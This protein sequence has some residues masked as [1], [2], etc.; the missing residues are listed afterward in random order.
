MPEEAGDR[1]ENL[2]RQAGAVLMDH[3]G[4]QLT[5]ETK[6]DQS[7]VT[8]ADLASEKLL[9]SSLRRWYPDD[10]VLAEE[11][12]LSSA[13]RR[14]GSAIWLIDP[15]DGTTNFANDYPFFCIS[16]ARGR[17]TAEGTIEPEWGAIYDPVRDELFTASA[18]KGAWCN[19]RRLQVR[20]PRPLSRCFLA[21]GYY[22]Q[23]GDVLREEVDRF[24]AVASVCQAIRRDGAAALDLAWVAR[25]TYDAFWEKG[26]QLWD[27][28][29][30]V[31]LIREAGGDVCNYPTEDYN[32][33]GEGVIAGSR[34]AV[35][36]VRDIINPS[37]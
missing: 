16:V 27:L 8:A 19:G 11:S 35:R 33:E 37:P 20:P 36:E 30:G 2:V 21:M 32:L 5:T 12:G 25:G 4:T 18:G 7:L 34:C 29:A 23:R 10:I 22:Y 24:A 14:P 26:L 17:F 1:L 28:A 13:G 15:L 3:Y 31:L 6:E 9:I